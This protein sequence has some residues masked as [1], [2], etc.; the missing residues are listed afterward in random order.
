MSIFAVTWSIQV[1]KILPPVMRGKGILASG[2]DFAQGDPSTMYLVS[3]IG[4]SPGHWKEF[5][6]LGFNAYNYLQGTQ[7]PPEIQRALLVQL[8]SDVFKNPVINI[9]QFPI[10]IVNGIALIPN[11]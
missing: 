4:S 1:Q 5:P 7:S 2:S 10:I 11:S 9:Q 3:I 8:Q 6:K